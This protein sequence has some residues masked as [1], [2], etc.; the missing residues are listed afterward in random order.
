LPITDDATR[1]LG[2]KM[3]NLSVKPQFQQIQNQLSELPI[4]QIA[5]N[6]GWQ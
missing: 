3:R 6:Y 4:A 5:G 1:C 2:L